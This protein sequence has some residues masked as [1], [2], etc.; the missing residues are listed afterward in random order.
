[1]DESKNEKMTS[2]AGA[3]SEEIARAI[4]EVMDDMKA[5]DIKILRVSEKT[6]MTDYFVTCSGTSNTQIRAISG[7]IE[8]KLGE[9]GLTPLHIE[10]Y[11]TGTWIAMDYAHVMVHIFN[12]E[13]RDFYKLEKLWG[14]ACEVP[15]NTENSEQED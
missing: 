14:D 5:H 8:Y 9:R 11:E 7:E 2:L 4:A 3:S 1:M 13:Q 10:G 12:R 15:L 6:A